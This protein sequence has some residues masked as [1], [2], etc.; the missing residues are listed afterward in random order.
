MR[1]SSRTALPSLS[2]LFVL[3]LCGWWAA[4]V[5]RAVEPVHVPEAPSAHGASS[6][7]IRDL[8]L[9]IKAL[10]DEFH[11]QLDPLQQQVKALRRSTTRS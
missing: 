11:S 9:Q 6:E 10:R 2:L 8:D 3:V 7:Q 5:A 1:S 4:S